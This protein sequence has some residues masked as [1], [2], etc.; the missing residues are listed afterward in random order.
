MDLRQIADDIPAYDHFLTIDEMAASSHQLVADYPDLASIRV[1]GQTRRGDP[2]ELLTIKGGDKQAFVFGGPHPNEPIGCMMLEYLT[3]RLCE[4]ADL[5]DELGYTWHFIKSIDS[6]GMRLNEG[7][8]GGP[9][10]P[11]NYAR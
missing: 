9:F 1:V 6:D 5:R 10:T 11:T 2:I 7:W 4:D 8:F 3:R